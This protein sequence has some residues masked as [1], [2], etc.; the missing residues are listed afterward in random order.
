MKIAIAGSGAMGG[1]IGL[2]LTE[3][4]QNVIMLDKWQ[5]HVDAM[6]NNGLTVNAYGKQTKHK[7]VAC[8]MDDY[9]EPVELVILLTKAL[10][11]E[12]TIEQLI[13]QGVITKETKVMS[14]MNGLG[15]G[16]MLFKK[17]NP[18]QV[19]LAVTM[20]SAGLK[21]PG[22]LILEGTGN[23]EFGYPDGHV[24]DFI[25]GLKVILDEAQLNGVISQD[26]VT[27]I[28]NK[29]LVNCCFNTYCSVTNKRI[30]EFGA[31]DKADEMLIPL[32]KE[33]I[34]VGATKGAKLNLEA[35]MDKFHKM[36]SPD[37]VGLHYPSMT[38]D[39][40]NGRKTEVDFLT[41]AVSRF[42]DEAGIDTPYCDILTHLVHQI[43]K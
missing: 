14:L 28:W 34:A 1:R 10:T 7:V 21:G 43:E 2:Y 30:G 9:R 8:H 33:I 24:D 35:T 26:I 29:A 11:A 31:Y 16:D 39:I 38:Q 12:E 3:C 42:G 20:W 18:E 17:L 19:I 36:Y 23:I 32:V 4:G 40:H 6:N 15:H 13:E 22:E 5:E 41:G 27:T 37:V 25:E